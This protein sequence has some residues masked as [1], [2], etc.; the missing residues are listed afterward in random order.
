MR[1]AL[2]AGWRG[3]M[4]RVCI[5]AGVMGL[6]PETA[7]ADPCGTSYPANSLNYPPIGAGVETIAEQPGGGYA[8]VI[9]NNCTAEMLDCTT[10][11]FPYGSNPIQL[12]ILDR[13]TLTPLCVETF[14][15]S[16]ADAATATNAINSWSASN[17]IVV[18]LAAL[19]T[20]NL[21]QIDVSWRGV[22]SSI[23]PEPGTS[24]YNGSLIFNIGGWSAIGVPATSGAPGPVGQINT[25]RADT[26]GGL[27]PVGNL[28]G[29]L[30]KQPGSQSWIFTTGGFAAFNTSSSRTETSNT[31]RIGDT[32]YP[33]PPLTGTNEATCQTG[34]DGSAPGGFHLVVLNA[35]TLSALPPSWGTPSQTFGTNCGD[36]DT[37]ID[38]IDALATALGK[39]LG[40][41]GGGGSNGGAGS[42]G[43]LV[44]LQ[45]I[46][47]PI[48]PT[49]FSQQQEEAARAISPLIEQLGGVADAFNKSWW[50]GG[51]ASGSPGYALAGST[52]LLGDA[53]S[54]AQVG[55]YGS[56][57]S[58]AAPGAKSP[59]LLDGLL[60]RN[61]L[62]RYEPVAAASVAGAAPAL[63]PT[64]VYQPSQPWLYSGE[65]STSIKGALTWF[66]NELGLEY[67]SASSCYEPAYPNVRFEYCDTNP[68][69][70]S[71]DVLASNVMNE[72][73]F[74]FPGEAACNCQEDDWKNVRK[75][76]SSEM[77]WVHYIQTGL[78][79]GGLSLND[80]LTDSSSAAYIDL[81]A[82]AN[83][84]LDAVDMANSSAAVV[85]F[86][87]TLASNALKFAKNFA[88]S[89]GL[90]PALGIFSTI[91]PL[92]ENLAALDSN[93]TL[94]QIQTTAKELPSE[95][96]SRFIAATNQLGLFQSI[97]V[98]DYGKLQALGT[99]TVFQGDPFTNDVLQ[100]QIL[101]GVKLFAY[102]R[103]LGSGYNGWG[104]LPDSNNPGYPSSPAAYSCFDNDSFEEVNP[105]E[106][107]DDGSVDLNWNG[108]TYPNLLSGPLAVYGGNPN[109]LAL[110]SKRYDAYIH[111]STIP[112]EVME[113]VVAGSGASPSGLADWDV[114][115]FRHNFTQ[116]G[117][118]CSDLNASAATRGL[119]TRVGTQG[120]RG[121]MMLRTSVDD[122]GQIDLSTAKLVVKEVLMEAERAGEV[123][124]SIGGS[125]FLPLELTATRGSTPKRAIFRTPH[126]VRPL[127]TVEVAK[128]R[129]TSNSLTVRLAVN[130]T[131]MPQMPRACEAE[132]TAMLRTRLVLD[133]GMQAPVFINLEQP[134]SCRR[135]GLATSVRNARP[136]LDSWGD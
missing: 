40:Y 22:I 31:M 111:Y 132:G 27:N 60:K 100:Q 78:T 46:G 3:V 42:G 18:I 103:L 62:G 47:T 86:W 130:R 67:D 94:G 30:Q 72:T 75:Q 2:L 66:S 34:S 51:T 11:T 56:E 38:G 131:A 5:V 95:L 61:Y 112:T 69:A 15:G 23:V 35:G 114:W 81:E 120:D 14:A 128:P 116:S 109:L 117:F 135:S 92:A 70:G 113:P 37:D 96:S 58:S 74:P 52:A 33:S 99:A 64:T 136:K 89:D 118:K 80:A 104:L 49:Q 28:S 48:V 107:N 12:A 77:T 20:S 4:L 24:Y 19:P 84:V 68:K 124:R 123:V 9:G 79:T 41:Q 102:G 45:S 82:T 29:Y 106:S 101:N 119:A 63:L 7:R 127:V 17:E 54:G 65:T 39:A 105:F 133:D 83:T 36:P 85:G 57:A 122:V 98:S 13:T 126:G 53:P 121:R 10:Y 44:F 115:F 55:V 97:I 25:G 1:T 21:N 59:V 43:A 125:P 16:A 108:F 26:Y 73:L 88:S 8:I 71:W 90:G 93:T 87:V 76:L 91:G 50:F 129:R 6:A 110:G 134:W 32:D